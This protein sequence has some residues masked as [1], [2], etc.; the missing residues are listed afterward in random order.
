MATKPCVA[1][2]YNWSLS[3]KL[4]ISHTINSK[5]KLTHSSSTRNRTEPQFVAQGLLWSGWVRPKNG[6]LNFATSENLSFIT[7][8]PMCRVD[9]PRIRVRTSDR[10]RLRSVC[11]SVHHLQNILLAINST[12]T[13]IHRHTYEG[14]VCLPATKPP[15]DK[16]ISN[17]LLSAEDFSLLLS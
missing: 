6:T 12:S 10:K 11:W 7:Y 4:A 15:A 16:Q 2:I 5:E 1:D 14:S 13:H 3:F 9:R 17:E 8:S